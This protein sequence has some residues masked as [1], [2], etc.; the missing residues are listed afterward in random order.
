MTNVALLYLISSLGV[1]GVGRDLDAL[2][3]RSVSDTRY[4]SAR[5]RRCPISR[6][7]SLHVGVKCP[8]SRRVCLRLSDRTRA[9]NGALADDRPPRPAPPSAL[10]SKPLAV[11]S[12]LRHLP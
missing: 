3:N 8:R 6:R 1:L 5:D 2:I 4:N 11:H 12:P 10:R 9:F 7:P